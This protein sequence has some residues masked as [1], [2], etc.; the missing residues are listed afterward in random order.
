MAETIYSSQ[1]C[2]VFT[3]YA[4]S[5]S[6]VFRM[7]RQNELA[8]WARRQSNDSEFQ[9]EGALTLKLFADNAN[10][11][12]GTES[13]RL[14]VYNPCTHSGINLDANRQLL[15]WAPYKSFY[16]MYMTLTFPFWRSFCC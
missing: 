7:L 9:T 11:I 1:K 3:V 5:N 13:N 4:M 16:C 12:R 15:L 10:T 8:S 14:S 6:S 2:R